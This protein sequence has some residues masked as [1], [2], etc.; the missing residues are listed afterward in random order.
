[1]RLTALDHIG[2][3]KGQY[4]A[5]R[6]GGIHRREATGKV[7][8]D[9]EAQSERERLTFWIGLADA[10]Y[11]R[12]ELSIGVAIQALLALHRLDDCGVEITPGDIER[13]RKH[14]VQAPMSERRLGR[15]PKQA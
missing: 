7:I 1:M 13:R 5:L 15:P 11:L 8:R 10:Q 12:K 3:V 14:Y 2:Q 4:L 9:F 6:S